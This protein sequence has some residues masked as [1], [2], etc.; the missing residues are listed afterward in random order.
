VRG[1]TGS[2]ASGWENNHVI[3]EQMQ[4]ANLFVNNFTKKNDNYFSEYFASWMRILGN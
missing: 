2:T 4:M 1:T 3:G